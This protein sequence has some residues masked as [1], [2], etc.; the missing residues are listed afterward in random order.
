MEIT[1]EDKRVRVSPAA[2]NNADQ[3][4]FFTVVPYCQFHL[5][6]RANG[7]LKGTVERWR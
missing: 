7:S 1:L 2:V 6:Q 5:A 4:S 3:L